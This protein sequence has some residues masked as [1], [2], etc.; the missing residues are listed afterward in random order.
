M[1]KKLTLFLALAV[2]AV[3]PVRA[4]YYQSGANPTGTR[5]NKLSGPHFDVIYPRE[6]DSLAREFLFAF[7]RDR[8]ADLAGLHIESERVPMILHPYDMNSNGMVVWAPKRTELITTPPYNPLYSL[9]WETQ[10]SVHEGRHIGQM[11]HYTKG[12]YHWLMLLTGEQGIGVGVGLYPSK[13]L[14]EGDAVQNETDLTGAGRGRDP[15]FLKFYRAAFLEKDFRQYDNWRYGSYHTYTPNKYAFGYM[16]SSIMRDNSGN[17]FV[18]G[19]I[20][21]EQV[22]SW[23]RF[24]SVSHRSYIRAS[25]LTTRKN[26]RLAVSRYNEMWSWEYKMRAPYTPTEPLLAQKPEYYT[27]ITNILPLESGLYATLGGVQDE[28]HLVRIDSLGRVIRRHAFSDNTSTLA[29]DGDGALFSEIVPDP[30]WE[31][32]S[33]SVIRRYDP[34]TNYTRTLTRRTRYVNPVPSPGRDSILAVDYKVSGGTDI[35]ILDREGELLDRIAAPAGSQAVNAALLGQTL[36]VSALTHDGAAIYRLDDEGWTPVVGPRKKS[37]RDL[38][39]AGDSLLYFISDLDGISNVYAYR[40]E[41]DDNRLQQ[42]TTV[43]VS[44]THPA[45]DSTG[46]LFFA[47]YDARGYHPVRVPGER[48]DGKEVSFAAGYE[49]PIATRNARQVEA[50]IPAR[51]A[52]MDSLL[53]S[54]IDSLESHPYRKILHGIHI[55]SWFPFYA[56]PDRIMN[57]IGRFNLDN[58]YRFIAPGVTVVSQNTLGTAVATA[59]YSWRHDEFRNYHGAHLNFSYSGL[60]PVFEAS[61]DYNDHARQH[62]DCRIGSDGQFQK[63]TYT[64]GLNAVTAAAMVYVPLNLSRGGWNRH[65]TPQL[66]YTLTNDDVRYEYRGHLYDVPLNQAVR[67]TVSYYSLLSRP[68]A[69]IRPRLGFGLTASG[70]VRVGASPMTHWMQAV[71]TYAYLPGFLKEDSFKLTYNYQQQGGALISSSN[72]VKMPRGYTVEEPLNH[73]NGFSLDYA[74]PLNT[75]GLSGGWLF[76]LKR[77]QV[78]PFTDFAFDDDHRFFSYGAS[79]L[80]NTYLFRIGTELGFGV[81]YARTLEGGPGHFRFILSTGF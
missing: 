13:R 75:N 44:A 29:A 66:S 36:Y 18:T 27:E 41:N 78:I 47:D 14:L 42:W 2:L 32:R 79:L 24:F 70:Q 60:Y 61:I 56:D 30:R 68:S 34:N 57:D 43:T 7:E 31:H 6:I 45:L 76:Y 40:P 4:Q 15:E 55:H 8:D 5:W 10:L 11:A 1:I 77:V 37:I 59:G 48:F 81:Q 80:L 53:R 51:T 50:N 46:T 52:E 73:Y 26:W 65:L 54:S 58:W 21:G 72:M 74:L 23:W 39:A 20:M 71:N 49:Q 38:R 9:D 12:I 3:L 19:D 22:K 63:I 67:A 17:Y 62:T 35:V 16:I 25:G 33:W 69:R 64:Y 28:T